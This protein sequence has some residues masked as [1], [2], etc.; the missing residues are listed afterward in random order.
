MQTATS[1]T[2]SKSLDLSICLHHYT[3]RAPCLKGQGT[4]FFRLLE[5]LICVSSAQSFMR[6]LFQDSHDS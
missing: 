2:E 5:I 1:K 4:S 6:K 3:L